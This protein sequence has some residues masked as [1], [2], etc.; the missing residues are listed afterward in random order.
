MRPSPCSAPPGHPSPMRRCRLCLNSVLF[1]HWPAEFGTPV[2]GIRTPFGADHIALVQI[3]RRLVA[4][5]FGPLAEL[6]PRTAQSFVGTMKE[7]AHHFERRSPP[8]LH[9]ADS[10]DGRRHRY[11]DIEI[12][13]IGCHL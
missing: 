8:R 4:I 5:V 1:D 3:A 12:E 11:A 10:R 9:A 7:G 6:V 2:G 13:S